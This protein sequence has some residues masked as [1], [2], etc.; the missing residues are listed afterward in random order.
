MKHG[1]RSEE[2]I[3]VMNEEINHF[4]SSF[5]CSWASH[6]SLLLPTLRSPPLQRHHHLRRT[7]TPHRPPLRPQIHH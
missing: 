2:K 7:Q 1:N 3:E 4:I 6:C 5:P